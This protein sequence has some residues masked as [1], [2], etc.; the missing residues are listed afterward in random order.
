MALTSGGVD[1]RGGG[2]RAIVEAMEMPMTKHT[3][4]ALDDDLTAFVEAQIDEGRYRTTE[5]VVV[6]AL[7]RL[8]YEQKLEALRAA[9]I[10]GE[11]SGFP[12]ED[13]D[14]DAFIASKRQ[15]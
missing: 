13:F 1:V 11:E 15:A 5:E 14:F 12:D 8:E 4:I 10:E 3:T 6:A 9:L 2:G 7:R